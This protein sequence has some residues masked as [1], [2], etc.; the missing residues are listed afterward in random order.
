MGTEHLDFLLVPLGLL[1]V[2]AYHAWLIVAIHRKPER[3]VIGLNSLAGAAGI[4]RRNGV[5]AV[6]TVRNN[7]MASTL[8]TTAAVIVAGARQQGAT[9]DLRQV[10]CDHRLLH[11]RIPLPCPVYQVLRPRE[12]PRV[13]A[14]VAVKRGGRLST[15]Y[16]AR[17]LN[18]GGLFWSLGLRAFYVSFNL[19]LWIFGPIAMFVSCYVM[20]C[21]LYF[22]DTTTQSTR[23]HNESLRGQEEMKE[24]V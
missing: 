9:G 6:Q 21:M 14:A 5:L 20:V 2:A 1:A 10:L 22:L 3:T 8:L 15:A 19:F 24:G 16:V 18:R 12:L 11:A 23:D 7:I 13:S 4:H 17:S